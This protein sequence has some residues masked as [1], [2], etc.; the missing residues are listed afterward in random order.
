MSMN[1][2]RHFNET[3]L[4]AWEQ[5]K[6][7]LDHASAQ[8]RDLS[9]EER[10]TF[11]R[12]NAEMD[13]C[14]TAVRDAHARMAHENEAAQLREG[15]LSMFGASTIA[16]AERRESDTLRRFLRG[17]P[18]AAREVEVPVDRVA[19]EVELLR[20]GATP[21]EARAMAWDATSGSL[22]VP[23]TLARS[24]YEY[25]EAEMAVWRMPTLRITSS[26]GEAM[27]LP[28]VA[29][30]AIG[31][32]VTSQNLAV[33][34]T[35]PV[36]GRVDL[37]VYKYG[38]LVQVSNELLT[39]SA[40]DV[41]SWLGRNIGRALGRVIGADLVV[42]TGSAEP[43]GIMT[44]AGVAGSGSVVTGGSLVT[45]SVEKYLDA[46]FQVADAYRNRASFG[47]LMKDSTLGTLR[48]LRDG[49]GGTV[50]AFL[51][52][53]STTNGLSGGA[54]TRFLGHPIWTDPSVAAQGS[55]AR[56]VWVGDASGYAVRTVGGVMIERSNEYGF[57][58]D[59]AYFRGK[60]RVG[61]VSVDQDSYSSIVMNV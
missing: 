60:W 17:D 34:G 48:K 3:R 51:L 7:L 55:N 20:Q 35:D 50:G 61:G 38:Q 41:A 42:G 53:A 16:T 4:R 10:Q 56:I 27:Q 22:V 11:D 44:A 45:P 14:E 57:N 15:A 25:L 59:S 49:A 2:V 28:T 8:G 52:D 31:T 58:T 39:D 36:M 46:M 33:G 1:E 54:I 23:T 9:A 37:P 12:L 19:R 6:S 24:V 40:F 43:Q 5:A 29:T 30:H 26:S 32:Q 18:M 21:H 13:D 47:W